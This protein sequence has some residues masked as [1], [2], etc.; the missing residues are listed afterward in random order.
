VTIVLRDAVPGDEAVLHEFDQALATFESLDDE[1]TASIEDFAAGLFGHDAPAKAL[2]AEIDGAIVGMAIYWFTFNTFSGKK[3]VWLEDLFVR[4]EARRQGVADALMDALRNL[5]PG[6]LEWDVL[7]WNEGALTLYRKLGAEPNV[8]WTKYGL[9][10][11][12]H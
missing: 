11:H 3:G 9:R 2:I 7:D 1:F 12:P 6:R 8:G 4:D 5:S 10:P